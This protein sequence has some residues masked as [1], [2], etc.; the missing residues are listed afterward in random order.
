[1]KVAGVDDAGRGPIIGP[2]LIAGVLVEEK[3]LPILKDL[4]VKDSKLLSPRRRVQLAEEIKKLA[5]KWH[6]VKLSPAEIDDVVENGRKLH[7]L[8]RLEARA[9]AEVIAFLKPEVAYVDASDVLAE[10]FGEHIQEYLPFKIKIISEHKADKKYM[11]VSAAS[12]IAK[13]ERDKAIEELAN[14]YGD[15]GSGYVTD[16]KTVVFL[17]RWVKKHGSYPDFVRKS[18]K[19]AKKLKNDANARQAKLV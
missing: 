5:L 4:G 18:W 9:M 15:M 8:N 16:P 14:K 3:N 7:K 11:V 19:P 2:L 6:F 10:R 1:M 17:K 12:I 13:V